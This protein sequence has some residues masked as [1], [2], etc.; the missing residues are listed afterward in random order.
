[1]IAPKTQPAPGG[2]SAPRPMPTQGTQSEPRPMREP[3]HHVYAPI[4]E[5]YERIV[6]PYAYGYYGTESTPNRMYKKYLSWF[7]A[8][9]GT[10][11]TPLTFKQWLKWAK[12]KGML[13]SYM[14]GDGTEQ[15]E[16]VVS[17]TK[18]EKTLKN[19]GKKIAFTIA[20]IA[21]VGLAVSFAG[22]KS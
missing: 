7:M 15:V 2:Q 11:K 19:T 21:A 13:T 9:Y 20:I 17:E 8:K 16:E 22:S 5:G 3:R 4:P 10:S 14:G 12:D 18:V 1:M 6:V